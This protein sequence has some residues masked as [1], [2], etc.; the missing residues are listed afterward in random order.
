MDEQTILQV[1]PYVLMVIIGAGGS[2]YVIFKKKMDAFR[3]LVDDVDDALA[4]DTISEAEFVKIYNDAKALL[5]YAP[6]PAPVT[7]T[8]ASAVAVAKQ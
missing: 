3:K 2:Y 8:E 7:K 5:G 6:S 1:M 4:D